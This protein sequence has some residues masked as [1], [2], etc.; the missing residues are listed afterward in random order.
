MPS[1]SRPLWRI[2]LTLVLTCA[3]PAF[4]S[5]AAPAPAPVAATLDDAA[6]GMVR[7]LF[8]PA[9]GSKGVARRGAA[10]RFD[11]LGWESGAGTAGTSAFG[12]E[13]SDAVRRSL[14]ARGLA[15]APPG[16]GD[17]AAKGVGGPV[18][19]GAFQLLKGGAQLSLAL[20]DANTGR[21][22]SEAR[23][24]LRPD[25][26]GAL[27]GRLLP[28]DATRVIEL[29]KWI[30]Q[31]VGD[32]RPPFRLDVVTDR[33]AHGAYFEG[34][35]LTLRVTAERD[36]WVRLFHVSGSER[37]LTLIY[38]NRSDTS[39]FLPAGVTLVAPSEG[40]GATF[41]VAPPYGVD[42]IVAFA[43]TTPFEDGDWVATQLAGASSG[44]LASRGVQRAGD[45]LAATDVSDD[46][47]R[48]VLARG[49]LVRHSAPAPS[50]DPRATA[51][52]VPEY[53]SPGGG[54]APLALDQF[55]AEA[56]IPGARLQHSTS[57]LARATC[58]FT[59]LPRPEAGR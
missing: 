42:A 30:H 33:G 57:P 44:E 10:V 24:M 56:T 1:R 16:A 58:F 26:Y 32:G 23:R 36:C 46:A 27:A 47:S 51:G 34:E 7:E 50:A 39:A 9:R 55:P 13:A 29:A 52:A 45:Y 4:A 20:V 53:P 3:I 38:P 5:G 28:P 17:A 2:G 41:E 48:G 11:G 19:R 40:S 43:S 14:A 21:V 12:L 6:T 15:V 59:T 25:S 49:L 31:S 37:R 18:L 22:I 54:T 8:S 35:R